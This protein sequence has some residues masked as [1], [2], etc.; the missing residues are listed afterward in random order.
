MKI[1]N[2]F[3]LV[4][5]ALLS[6]GD[7]IIAMDKPVPVSEELRPVDMKLIFMSRANQDIKP[8]LSDGANPNIFDVVGIKT[9]NIST[10]GFTPLHYACL[11]CNSNNAKLLLEH[12]ANVNLKSKD[13][14]IPPIYEVFS[15]PRGNA[16]SRYKLARLL[17]EHGADVTAKGPGNHSLLQVAIK[18]NNKLF[19]NELLSEKKVDI[20]TLDIHGNNAL[21]EAVAAA[22]EDL[23]RK[24]FDA[25][26]APV[27][28]KDGISLMHIAVIRD[29][30]REGDMRVLDLLIDKG[31][32]DINA[33]DKDGQSPLH[34]AAEQSSYA[35]VKKLLDL[36]ADPR[37]RDNKGRTAL[38][39]SA[40][41][42]SAT[43]N[44]LLKKAKQP[45]VVQ[46]IA[47]KEEKP[48]L[49]KKEEKKAEKVVMQELPKGEQA[50]GKKKNKPRKRKKNPEPGITPS[51]NVPPVGTQPPAGAQSRVETQ[52]TIGAPKETSATKPMAEKAPAK[53]TAAASV[54]PKKEKPSLKEKFSA[55]KQTVVDVLH[56]ERREASIL[57]AGKSYAVAAGAPAQRAQQP[58]ENLITLIDD[59]VDIVAYKWKS[60]G[61]TNP[62]IGL[63]YSK[64]VQEKMNSA[65]DVFHNFST[66]VE[67]QLGSFMDEKV[68]KEATKKHSATV[69]YT[70]PA[71]MKTLNK[72]F[73]GR[74]EFVV[75]DGKI[76]H[77]FFKPDK[78]ANEKYFEQ[79]EG[80]PLLLPAA[81][82]K[83][84]EKGVDV[85]H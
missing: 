20:H 58:E 46:K 70:I 83:Y 22:D 4:L 81:P 55:A 31:G 75:R 68:T 2:V 18:G 48:A 28:D 12:G 24:L 9:M 36:G 29:D 7:V 40:H 43:V 44:M 34:Y 26:V 10:V 21:T 63:P 23:I 85:K 38:Q 14:N 57:Q 76:I 54:K 60:M 74:F 5:L 11:Y 71:T 62:L 80:A 66:Q 56:P 15:S 45:V 41:N 82:T 39:L 30:V 49:K 51:E 37:I 17:I 42:P 3:L 33:V 61:Q 79:E 8:V 73:V 19:A 25:G 52:Q 78:S 47:K 72:E 67:A 77:R 1:K 59:R 65:S 69:K 16:E 53:E 84:Q 50:P 6:N 35:V 64:H 13:T 27:I 32:Y